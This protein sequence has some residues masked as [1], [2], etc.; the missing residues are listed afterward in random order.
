MD[1]QRVLWPNPGAHQHSLPSLQR[2]WITAAEATLRG[3]TIAGKSTL[4]FYKEDVYSYQVTGQM[5]GN[6]MLHDTKRS[7]VL[8]AGCGR[9]PY[10]MVKK[11]P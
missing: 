6:T 2:T 3:C 1:V 4:I 10:Q 5:H 11:K 7:S 9:S 8:V